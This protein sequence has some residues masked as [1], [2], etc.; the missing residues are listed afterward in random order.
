MNLVLFK[1]GDSDRYPVAVLMKSDGTH[2][3]FDSISFYNDMVRLEKSIMSSRESLEMMFENKRIIMKGRPKEE[4][5]V[6]KVQENIYRL[7]KDGKK[8]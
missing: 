2:E 3:V 4:F 7:C 5:K 1:E 6:E 8:S